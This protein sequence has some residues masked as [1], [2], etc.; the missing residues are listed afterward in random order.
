MRALPVDV[1]WAD[2]PWLDVRER[3]LA[4]VV[5]S[6]DPHRRAHRSGDGK[7]ARLA[8]AGRVCKRKGC[9]TVLSRYNRA[10]RCARHR[11]PNRK[12][13]DGPRR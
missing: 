10:T 11:N 2:D 6:E 1:L 4:Q 12:I 13:P 7:Q 8:P 9:E 3:R 5:E